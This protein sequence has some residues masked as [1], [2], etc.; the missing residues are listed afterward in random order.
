MLCDCF[1]LI[2]DDCG[3]GGLATYT[4]NHVNNVALASRCCMSLEGPFN[5]GLR[6]P[7]SYGRYGWV[8]WPCIAMSV[9]VLARSSLVMDAL[10]RHRHC[11]HI[12]ESFGQQRTIIRTLNR[13]S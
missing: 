8:P 13:I 10:T 1:C 4:G 7:V 6:K 2:S 11:R 12:V 9:S 5:G 3:R